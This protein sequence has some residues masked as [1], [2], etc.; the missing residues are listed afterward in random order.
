MKVVWTEP[1]DNDREQIVSYIALDNP[2][3]A[4]EM[5]CLFTEA[6]ASLEK[7]AL[8]G[9]IG[10]ASNTRELL[11]HK[12]YIIVYNVDSKAGIVYI[13][14]VLHSAQQYPPE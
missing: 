13:T 1:A 11:V 5:D 6:G 7:F 4:I 2:Q 10:R 8:R 12:N 3:A 14:A 9:R